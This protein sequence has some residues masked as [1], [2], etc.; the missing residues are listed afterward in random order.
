MAGLGLLTGRLIQQGMNQDRYG[1]F[2][3][4]TLRFHSPL[5]PTADKDHLPG[6]PI[7]T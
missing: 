1:P 7:P 4:Q 3:A 6:R 2:P 5:N